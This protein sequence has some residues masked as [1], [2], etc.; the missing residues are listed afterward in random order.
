MC[1]EV[2][3]SHKQVLFA[4]IIALSTLGVTLLIKLI[5]ILLKWKCIH[6]KIMPFQGETKIKKSA[7]PSGKR[8]Y[9]IVLARSS[10]V[11]A[12]N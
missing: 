12:R 10:E 3:A 8:C 4:A 5:R 2:C 11:V 7:C 9:S 1:F 6:G